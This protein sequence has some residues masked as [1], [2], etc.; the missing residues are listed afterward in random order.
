MLRFFKGQRLSFTASDEMSWDVLVED[1]H[2]FSMFLAIPEGCAL[3]G[4]KEL[5]FI[6]RADGVLH[7]LI[8]ESAVDLVGGESKWLQLK[9]I[10]PGVERQPRVV[11][12]GVTARVSNG[13]EFAFGSVCDLSTSGLLVRIMGRWEVKSVVEICID[14]SVGEIKMVGRVARVLLENEAD[15]GD[16]GI[17][18]QIMEALDRARYNLFVER[19]L[20][21]SLK[22]A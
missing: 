15:T 11:V 14:T 19:M 10:Y 2:N 1:V 16:V 3:A 7:R 20:R 21:L 9:A 12:S 5:T 8:L 6:Y 22:A 13:E 18:I 4:E 17:E